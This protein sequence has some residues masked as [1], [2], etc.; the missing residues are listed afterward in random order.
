MRRLLVIL[1]A[2][3]LFSLMPGSSSAITTE[4]NPSSHPLAA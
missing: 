3:M 1:A 2:S 4:R